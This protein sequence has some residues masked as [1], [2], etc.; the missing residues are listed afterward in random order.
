MLNPYWHGDSL[1][2]ENKAWDA[3]NSGHGIISVTP[4]FVHANNLPETIAHPLHPEKYVYAI[5]AYHMIHCTVRISHDRS[6]EQLPW[7]LTSFPPS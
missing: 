2:P 6:Q 3:I 7:I 1:D 5:E 4:E